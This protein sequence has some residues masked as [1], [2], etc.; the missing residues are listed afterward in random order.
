MGQVLQPVALLIIRASLEQGSSSP[1]RVEV[2]TTRDVA[3][4]VQR[5]MTLT[6]VEPVL[7]EVRRWLGEFV[8]RDAPA[9]RS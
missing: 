6:E 2:R 4:G 1:L 3:T 9:G 7:A 5:T 8:E